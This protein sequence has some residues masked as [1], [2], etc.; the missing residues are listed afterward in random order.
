MST[1]HLDKLLNPKSIAVVGASDREGA[2]GRA[3][4]QSLLDGQFNG[5]LQFVNPRY[6]TV[7]GQPCLRSL[8]KLESPPDLI[9]ILVPERIIRRTL[10]Q[11]AGSACKVVIVMSAVKDSKSIHTLAQKLGIRMI[12]PYCA[13]MIRPHLKLNATYSNNAVLSGSL[14]IVTQSASLGAAILDWAEPS[15]VGFSAVLSTGADTDVT[16]PDLL[17]LLS[18]DFHTKA[19]IVYLDHVTET[20]AFLS[21]ISAAARVKPVVLMKS[22]QDAARYCDALTRTGQ[23]YSTEHVFQTAMRRAGVVRVRTFSNLFSAAKIL[24]SSL[25]IKGKRIA[26][27]SNGAAP[28]MLACERIADKHYSLPELPESILGAI[29]KAVGSQW[30]GKNPVVLR[31]AENLSAQYRESLLALKDASSIDALLV[32]F[33]PDARNNPDD[34]AKTIIEHRP[35]HIPVL[36]SFMGETSVKQSRETL[37]HANVPCFRTP[38]SATDAIDFLHRYLVSQQQLLQ[39]PNPTSRY[40]RADATSAR[41]LIETALANGERVLGPQKTRTLLSLFDIDVLPAK[42]VVTRE[43]AIKHAEKLGYPIAMKLVS[44]NIRYKSEVLGTVLN[45]E[46]QQQLIDAYQRIEDK[47]ASVRPDAEFRGVL[48]ER[49]HTATNTRN[50]SM[51]LMRDA[52]FGPVISVGVGGD[53]SALVHERAAQLPPLNNFLID[54][55]LTTPTIENYLGEYRHQKPVGRKAAAHVLRR[56]SEMACELPNVFSVDINPLKVSPDGAIAM[57]VQVV[58]ERT[59]TAKEYAHLAIH[60]YPWRWVRM[61][62]LKH[63][64]TIQMRPIRPEDGTALQAMVQNMSAESRYYRFMHAIN[65]LSPQLIAQFTKLDYDR[66]MAFVA[67]SNKSNG[68]KNNDSDGGHTHHNGE[69]IGVGRYSMTSDRRGAE[70]AVSIAD[71]WQGQGLAS[72][73]MKLV[74][75]HARAQGLESIFGDVLVTNSPMR[76]LMKSLGFEASRDP[77][78]RELLRFTLSLTD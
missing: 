63:G 51:S 75:E 57:E 44:P 61:Q 30:T 12:G 5:P 72:S 4:A 42:R 19:I 22:T 55:M 47:M 74:I 76:G 71:N 38:E 35:K 50:L 64:R 33:A 49:M 68:Q 77:N 70:F 7:L 18:E 11:A 65:D 8:K 23:V 58:L 53:L 39:L 13:G 25:R 28:A 26:I 24:T 59:A 20:R 73:L 17:D 31:D 14:A 10:I 1:I 60:P 43:E 45:I 41:A 46:N 40:T 48:I 29:K 56:L 2:P 15:G 32:L 6:K 34:I 9:I 62:K 69:V 16:L 67:I 36:T 37:A 27:I 78:D 21:A 3:I 54:S 66:Q 52:T